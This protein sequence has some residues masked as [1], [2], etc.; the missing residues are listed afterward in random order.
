MAEKSTVRSALGRAPETPSSE[1]DLHVISKVLIR[2]IQQVGRVRDLVSIIQRGDFLFTSDDKDYWQLPLLLNMW[3]F[4][5]V[6]WNN[7]YMVCCMAAF[8]VSVIP[9]MYSTVKQEICKLRG[10]AWGS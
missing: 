4:M 6:A 9:W 1:E 8:G 2:D 3:P 10:V 5:G 7:R